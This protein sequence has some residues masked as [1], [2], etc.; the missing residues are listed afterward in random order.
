MSKHSKKN[1]K[2]EAEVVEAEAEL[3]TLVA[4]E[5]AA[6]ETAAVEP[7]AKK[8]AKRLTEAQLV[9]RYPNVVEGTLRMEAE[10][11]HVGKQTV[12]ATL[13]CGH[14]ARVA[15]SDLFQVRRCPDCKK[16]AKKADAKKTVET[17]VK[18]DAKPLSAAGYNKAHPAWVEQPADELLEAV[19]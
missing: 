17:S 11:K 16:T 3:K 12:E 5:I 14:V 2:T 10:G 8:P 7:K 6:D 4:A 15:T 9:E 18:A 13:A 19:A 1:S